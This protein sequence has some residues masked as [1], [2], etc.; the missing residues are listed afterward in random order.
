MNRKHYIFF[1][2]GMLLASCNKSYLEFE[3][4]YDKSYQ[5][6]LAFKKSS[7]NSYEYMVTDS[8]WVGISWETV[9]IVNDGVIIRR[10]FKEEVWNEEH[11]PEIRKEWI[12]YEHEINTTINTAAAQAMTMDTI[13]EKAKN[14]WLRKRPAAETYFQAE[15][16]GLISL[17]GYVPYECKD[18]CFRGI[19]IAYIKPVTDISYL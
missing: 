13:Y 8:S 16:D 7:G 12:E 2:F 6:W 3:S 9:I 10:Y 15:N 5:E 11:I 19:S 18:D 1:L 14:D 17:C 4:E